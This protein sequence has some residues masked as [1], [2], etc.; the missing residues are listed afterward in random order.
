MVNKHYK[1]CK[2]DEIYLK[3]AKRAYIRSRAKWTFRAYPCQL[4]KKRQEKNSIIA[5]LIHNPV[6]TYPALIA[7][8]NVSNRK[9]CPS[10]FSTD[11]ADSFNHML[12]RIP[13]NDGVNRAMR[14][15]CHLSQIKRLRV[16]LYTNLQGVMRHFWDLFKRPFSLLL[17]E[18][19]GNLASP[20]IMKQ[21]IRTKPGKNPKILD[22][23]RPTLTT[24]L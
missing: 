17:K 3:K 2:L 23:L 1:I 5:L 18:A 12:Y 15:W 22:N 19:T 13:H 10:A 21:G 8:E 16:C 24:K 11:D 20:S 4:E 6:N 7:K 9:L 14:C